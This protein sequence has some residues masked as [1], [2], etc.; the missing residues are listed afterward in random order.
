MTTMSLRRSTRRFDHAT[1]G[2]HAVVALVAVAALAACSSVTAGE[3]TVG[4]PGEGGTASSAASCPTPA[5]TAAT[6]APVTGTTRV[7]EGQLTVP[8]PGTFN[9]AG[10]TRTYTLWLPADYDGTTPLPLVVNYHGTGG[11][12]ATIDEFSSTLSEKAAARDMIVVAPQGLDG[13]AVTS[14]W[15]VPG[16][17]TAPDDI[18][19]TDALIDD[20]ATT[21]CIDRS[22][23]YAT[24]FS[25]GGAMT[26]WVACADERF[27]AAAPGGGVN[28]VD[29]SCAKAQ[30]PMYAYHGTADDVAYYNGIDNQPSQPNP[31]TAGTVPFFGSVEQ[32]MDVWAQHNGCDVQR[33][34]QNLAPDAILRTYPNCEAETR[35]LLA[36]GG[37]HTFPGGTTRLNGALGETVT[38]VNMADLMLDWFL[39]QQRPQ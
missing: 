22:R 26:T 34:D 9:P 35:V 36:V 11:T 5:A 16:F 7:V 38:S 30:I 32:V 12:P 14:R 21:Y 15:V 19:F 25:S 8:P 33:Q 27:A 29:P 3:A 4:S 23:V 20:L 6:T 24:G 28:L 10:D 1:R 2:V 18:A 17:G 37:G 39:T 13:E 31:A